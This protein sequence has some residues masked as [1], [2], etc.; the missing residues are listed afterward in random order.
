MDTGILRGIITAILM[1]A[2][3]GMWIWAYSAKRRATFDS[4]ARMPLQED[5]PADGRR[6]DFEVKEPE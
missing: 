4:A 2:F 6:A 1:V 3:L 5:F